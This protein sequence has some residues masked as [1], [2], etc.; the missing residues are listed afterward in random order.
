MEEFTTI[1]KRPEGWR[2]DCGD[3]IQ[4]SGRL[5]LKPSTPHKAAQMVPIG[6]CPLGLL[7]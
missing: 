5:A 7:P 1:T 3:S 2:T 4:P 6:D